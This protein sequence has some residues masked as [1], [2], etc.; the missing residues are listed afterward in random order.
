MLIAINTFF[1]YNKAKDKKGKEGKGMTTKPLPIGIDDYKKLIDNGYYYVDKTLLIKEL[2]DKKG[3]VNLFTRPRRFGKT[4]ALSMLQCYFEIEKDAEGKQI[5]NDSY[6]RGM[7]ILNAGDAYTSKMGQYPVISLSL[8]SA[9]QPT[10]EMAYL[11]LVDEIAKEYKRHKEILKS[12]IILESD[13]EHYRAIMEKRADRISY[14]KAIDFLSEMLFTFN[15]RKVI[16]LLDEYD[17]PLEN[18]YFKGYYT[19]MI[20]FIRSLFESALKTNR[21]LEFAVITGCLRISKESIFTGL[22]NLKI[23]S[24]TSQNFSEYFGFIQSEVNRILEYY[25]GND[26]NSEVQKW[27]D[28]YFFGETEVYNPWSVI[29]YVDNNFS[30]KPYWSNTS[31]NSIIR[32]LV[33]QADQKT[34]AELQELMDGGVIEKPVHE[35]I[36]YE[37]MNRTNDNLWN[38]L[39]FTGY[40]K[41]IAERQEE[42]NIYL[43]MALPNWEVKYIYENT[44]MEWFETELQKQNFSDLYQAMEEMDTEKIRE[45]ITCQLSSTISFMDYAEN[46]YHGFLAGILSQS[47]KYIVKSNREQGNGRSDIYMYTPSRRGRAFVLELKM[48]DSMAH[49]ETRCREGLEQIEK[50]RYEQELKADGYENITCYAIAFFQKDCEVLVK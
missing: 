15:G 38:F 35:D 24:I 48:A 20:D 14:A 17:V 11:S 34:K 6:F 29:N 22:N 10:F 45:I 18:A 2:L 39:F 33:E 4:L 46:F 19:E 23:I 26:K 44:I 31:S 7:K 37:D 3:E 40:L 42:R 43:K 30:A 32:H 12:N 16:I 50:N 27:Y 47:R 1:G 49:L 41:K 36:T 8:K 21:N 28:G 25:E 9:K 5:C 13:K